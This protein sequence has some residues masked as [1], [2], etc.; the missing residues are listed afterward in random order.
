MG[1]E[2]SDIRV[3]IVEAPAADR[4]PQTG[5]VSSVQRADIELPEARL[6]VLWQPENLERLARAYWRYLNRLSLGLLRVVYE[7]AARIVVLL[8]RP[9]ALLRFRAPQY[10][11][12]ERRASVTWPIDRG[13]LVSKGGHGKGFLRITV[14]RCESA[15]EGRAR[16][17]VSAE[18]ANFYP[19]L[20]GSGRFARIG[21][22]VYSQTQVRIHTLVTHGFLRSLGRGELPPSRVGALRGEIERGAQ[23]EPG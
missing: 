1:S 12:G 23:D 5:A 8:F 9:L 16:L 17:R 21:T 14:E 3:R 20:R 7:P 10:E 18:V 19:W 15:E 2:Q 13:L 22:W 4:V 6:A 11:T